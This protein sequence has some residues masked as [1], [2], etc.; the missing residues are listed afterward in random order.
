[1]QNYKTQYYIKLGHKILLCIIKT[2]TEECTSRWTWFTSDTIVDDV[3]CQMQAEKAKSNVMSSLLC[4][5]QWEHEA[6]ETQVS[7]R[8]VQPGDTVLNECNWQGTE[9]SA[10][11]HLKGPNIQQQQPTCH[12]WGFHVFPKGSSL[13]KL[14]FPFRPQ[15]P[16]SRVLPADTPAS[17]VL[18]TSYNT[19]TRLS[20]VVS[21]VNESQ[22]GKKYV[23]GDCNVS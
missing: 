3:I 22:R 13:E 8:D 15:S 5:S 4:K 23:Q 6:A 10:A 16:I 14:F 7:V 11:S 12:R 17:I 1:M 19:P 20:A 9:A 18:K 2:H 21:T